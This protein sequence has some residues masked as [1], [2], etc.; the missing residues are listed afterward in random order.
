ME[1]L[2]VG[3]ALIASFITAFILQKAALNVLLR[4]LEGERRTIQN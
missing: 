4:A 1:G 3:A 2:V